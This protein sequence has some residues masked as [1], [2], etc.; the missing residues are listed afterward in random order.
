MRWDE[1]LFFLPRNNHHHPSAMSRAIR[2]LQAQKFVTIKERKKTATVKKIQKYRPDSG[3]LFYCLY[4]I[5]SK[6]DAS[7][8][9]KKFQKK[10]SFSRCRVSCEF[11]PSYSLVRRRLLVQK[12]QVKKKWEQAIDRFSSCLNNPN[13][14]YIT[15]LY[16]L[17]RS[18]GTRYIVAA[19]AI[20]DWCLSLLCIARKWWWQLSYIAHTKKIDVSWLRSRA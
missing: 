1:K 7:E 3:A 6:W 12:N 13:T 15:K 17:V 20:A 16:L 8:E 14:L 11:P 19:D 2:F 18:F 5:N 9:G 10:K 4:K